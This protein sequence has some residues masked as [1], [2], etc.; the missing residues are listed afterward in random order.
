MKIKT[1]FI[2]RPPVMKALLAILF[3]GMVLVFSGCGSDDPPGGQDGTSTTTTGDNSGV[4]NPDG[5]DDDGTGDDGGTSAAG[6]IPCEAMT[7]VG[8]EKGSYPYLNQIGEKIAF[9]VYFK[10]RYGVYSGLVHKDNVH[11]RAED[12]AATIESVTVENGIA[13]AELRTHDG[14]Y[15]KAGP[16][17]ELTLADAVPDQFD[18]WYGKPFGVP[19]RGRV[20][21][22]WHTRGEEWFTEKAGP[23]YN[24]SYDEG[25]HYVDTEDDPF[26]DEN[27]NRSWDAE[28]PWEDKNGNGRF[29]EGDTFTDTNKNGVWD[30]GEHFVDANGND[31]RDGVN[32]KWDA[33]KLIFGNTTFVLTGDQPYIAWDKTNITVA[34]GGTGSVQVMACDYNFNHLPAGATVEFSA[35]DSKKSAVPV[36]PEKITIPDNAAWYGENAVDQ[37]AI[38]TYSVNITNEVADEVANEAPGSV[39]LIVKVSGD[40]LYETTAKI[41][42]V[43]TFE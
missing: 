4:T 35:Q 2:V 33:D 27:E 36:Y 23:N 6:G 42:G 28:E 43:V 31:Q 38:F 15:L 5:T 11:F 13:T 8:V 22:L 17:W 25:E 39:T 24:D 34:N 37:L 19:S 9:S 12:G 32:G 7:G 41:S 18:W 20:S 3:L 14:G 21:V 40:G 29:D 10:D 26:L 1:L 16:A 30:W